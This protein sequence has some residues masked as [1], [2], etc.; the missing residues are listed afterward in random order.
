M[1]V[2]R[3]YEGSNWTVR[4]YPYNKVRRLAKSFPYFYGSYVSFMMRIKG[5]RRGKGIS[6]TKYEW[7]LWRWDVN[8]KER[9]KNGHGEFP[10]PPKGKIKKKLDMGYISIPGQY[11]LDMRFQET[12]DGKEGVCSFEQAATFTVLDRDL[13][14][15]Q[16]LSIIIGGAIG[17]VIGSGITLLVTFLLDKG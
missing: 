16:W 13:F 1:P 5:Q 14:S 10:R 9:V 6:A 7:Q 17:A 8:T 15:A 4:I 12:T 3:E 11:I 2:F